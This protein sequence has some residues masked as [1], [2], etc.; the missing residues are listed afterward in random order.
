MNITTKYDSGD[1]VWLIDDSD[2]INTVI[3]GIEVRVDNIG[4]FTVHYKFGHTASTQTRP[5]NKVFKDK[6]ELINYINKIRS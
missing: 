2:I 4:E 5:E 3:I 1:S 6:E